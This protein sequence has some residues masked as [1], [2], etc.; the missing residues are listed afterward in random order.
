MREKVFSKGNCNYLLKHLF[1]TIFLVSL[2]EILKKHLKF[3]EPSHIIGD[4]NV[5]F[6]L[7]LILVIIFPLIEEIAF[8]LTI[9]KNNFFWKLTITGSAVARCFPCFEKTS[10][11]V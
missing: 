9:N 7:I 6:F 11:G 5:D 3:S 10:K 8:R 4:E 1:V 2:I